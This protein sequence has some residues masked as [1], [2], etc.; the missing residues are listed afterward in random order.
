ML[1][2]IKCI[3][4][5]SGFVEC[6]SEVIM[7]QMRSAIQIDGSL[8]L[9]DGI[10]GLSKLKE[11]C[12]HVELCLK[13]LWVYRHRGT[14]V[15]EGFLRFTLLKVA[16]SILT[17]RGRRRASGRLRDGERSP[18]CCETQQHRNEDSQAS[19]QGDRY[20]FSMRWTKSLH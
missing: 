14:E 10:R 11:N 8:E 2:L 9:R 4:R 6:K 18:N 20:A 17:M 7:T 15:L 3:D 12:T 13:V 1:I 5:T 19:R 16:K